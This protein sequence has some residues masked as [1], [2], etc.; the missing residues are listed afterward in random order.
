MGSDPLAPDRQIPRR[1]AEAS[2]NAT[3]PHSLSL[4][5]TLSHTLKNEEEP[6]TLS[7]F[8][9]PSV[10]AATKGEQMERGSSDR[11]F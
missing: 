8:F 3:S 9:P 7:N 1:E 5:H 6:L 10:I 2:S 4:S 11:A